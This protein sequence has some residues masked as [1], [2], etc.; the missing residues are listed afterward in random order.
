M[1]NEK[2]YQ[3][4]LPLIKSIASRYKKE[5][6]SFEDLV[7]EGFLGL[8][9]AEK[10]F[11]SSKKVK[12]STYAFYWIKKRILEAVRKE[13]IQSLNSLELKDE[14]IANPI[15]EKTYESK[16]LDIFLDKNL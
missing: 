10:R 1:K 6:I 12:F 2:L 13:K 4:Y 14:I 7:Q 11:D 5:G 9:E 3:D 15:I 8:L 16:E